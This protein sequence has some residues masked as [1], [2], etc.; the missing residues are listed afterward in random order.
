MPRPPKPL[1]Q[2]V[3]D[4][5]YRPCKDGPLPEKLQSWRSGDGPAPGPPEKPTD[6]SEEASKMWDHVLA[7]VPG[8]VWPSDLVYLVM[9]CEWWALWVD[10]QKK[11]KGSP[12]AV[13]SLTGFGIMTDKLD[14]LG[15]KFGLS[16]KDRMAMPVVEDGPKKA[17]VD[18][19][20]PTDLDRQVDSEPKPKRSRKKG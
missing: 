5:S 11:M 2:K 19:R 8:R 15:A 12:S 17:R 1:E 3:L 7:T 18:S 4:G 16:P 9:Y 14:K 13:K 10:A 20:Q 6:L